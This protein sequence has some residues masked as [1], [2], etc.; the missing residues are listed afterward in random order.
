MRKIILVIVTALFLVWIMNFACAEEPD[1]GFIEFEE[2]EEFDEFDDFE[3]FDDFADFDDVGTEDE[4]IEAIEENGDSE[5]SG[6]VSD[7]SKEEYKAKVQKMSE[8]SG[9][10]DPDLK[11]DGDYAYYV[12]DDETYCITSLYRGSS[13]DIIVPT[14]LGGYPV[15]IIGDHTFENK[16]FIHSVEVPDGVVAIGKQAFFM[17]ISLRTV[18]VPEGV[19]MFGDQC[20][21][22]CYMLDYVQVPDSLESVGEMAFLGC[23]ALKEIEFGENL[24]F[25]GSCAFH[26]CTELERVTVPSTGVSIDESAFISCP[27][28]MEVIYLNRL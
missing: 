4:Y 12:S 15:K 2:V 22:A 1:D 5:N 21:A 19:I 28:N 27:E 6:T 10:D 7:Q 23:Y 11:I 8:I 14:T 26:T 20:F 16:S 13:T 17:C 24:K 25:I 3:E 9:Y 18:I